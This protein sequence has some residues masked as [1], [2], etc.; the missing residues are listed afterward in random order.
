MAELN[1]GI[2]S[3]GLAAETKPREEKIPV[4][5]RDPKEGVVRHPSGFQPPTPET[6]FHPAVAKKPT[7][8]HPLLETIKQRWDELPVDQKRIT[9]RRDFDAKVEKEFA[10]A[11]YLRDQAEMD[12]AEVLRNPDVVVHPQGTAAEPAGTVS[13]LGAHTTAAQRAQIPT[14]SW[15]TPERRHVLT[16]LVPVAVPNH[17]RSMQRGTKEHMLYVYVITKPS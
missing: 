1:A 4:E 13:P 14:S 17:T 7:E 11:R 15:D 12:A 10:Q 5:V 9:S 6:Q 3:E 16:R 2:L 8:D